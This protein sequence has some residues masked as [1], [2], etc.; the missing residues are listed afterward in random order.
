MND[1]HAEFKKEF[2]AFGSAKFIPENYS[3]VVSDMASWLQNN[4]ANYSD[5]DSGFIAL[6]LLYSG[7]EFN[8]E[9]STSPVFSLCLID[10]LSTYLSSEDQTLLKE[11]REDILISL[12]QEAV[13][14]DDEPEDSDAPVV[15]LLG[16]NPN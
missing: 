9:A 16:A 13:E 5:S 14:F 15:V 11:S 10:V 12:V 4:F 8:I 1:F 2:L 6:T 3:S 7:L